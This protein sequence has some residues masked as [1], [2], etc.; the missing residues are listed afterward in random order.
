MK[1]K[2]NPMT[3]C[4]WRTVRRLAQRTLLAMAGVG[5]AACAA[6]PRDVPR[7]GPPALSA[8][9][10]T[11]AD[12]L[13]RFGRDQAALD[14]LANE[15]NSLRTDADWARAQC[16]VQ[17]A[18]SEH[19]ENER[20]GFVEAALGQ[21]EAITRALTARTAAPA[22]AFIDH[23][24]PMRPD[25]WARAA[26]LRGNRC[27]AATAGCLEVQ[28]VRAGHEHRTMGWRHANS[29]FA[30][31]EDLAAQG[32]AQAAAC[33]PVVL[34]AVAPA[35]APAPI[36]AAAAPPAAPAIQRQTL[37]LGADVLFRF[38]QS[39]TTQALPAGLKQLDDAAATLKRVDLRSVQVVGHT[40]PQGRSAYNQQLGMRRAAAVRALLAERG[41]PAA[42]IEADSRGER[43]PVV[44]CAAKLRGLARVACNQPNRRVVI[45]FTYVAPQ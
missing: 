8:A 21:A 5:L 33:A 25:L 39:R 12:L 7:D 11:G 36:V 6:L 1:V 15:R 35:P 37:T 20:G 4:R 13:A 41:V 27:A 43:E 26:A 14:A 38:D 9:A 31:A 2:A 30:I 23:S 18:Y 3:A 40:D 22:T 16:F 19:H 17:H 45:Q 42:L 10:I 34:A 28:L 24:E 44:A 29:H 32:T